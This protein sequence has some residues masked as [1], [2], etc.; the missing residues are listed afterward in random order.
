MRILHTGDWHIGKIINDFS[1]IEDQ[2]YILNKFF[3]IVETQKPDIIIITG[4]IY[5]RSI[6]PKEAVELLDETLTKLIEN[7]KIPT[8]IISGNHDSQERL[9][10][11]SR[12]LEGKKL[13]IEGLLRDKIKKVSFSD[14]YGNVNFYL[15]P[16]GHPSIIKNIFNDESITN[17]NKA[18]EVLINQIKA[19]FNKSERNVLISHNYV[20]SNLEEIL[21]SDSERSLSIGGT[22]YVDVSLVEDFDYVALGHLHKNQKVKKDYIRYSG[23]LLKYSFSETDGDKGVII[24]DLKNKGEYSY[25]FIKLVPCK[26]MRIIKGNLHDLI[27]PTFYNK[28]NRHDYI[29]AK[30]TDE[31]DLYDPISSL[32]AVYPNIMQLQRNNIITNVDSNTRAKGNF[33]NKSKLDLFKEFYYNLACQDLDDSKELV[34]KKIIEEVEKEGI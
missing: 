10:F 18:F 14:K 28:F 25:D 21:K 6:P 7:Y 33:K 12:L 23:S 31:T 22:E 3:E 29:L 1:L 16:Y 26:D 19:E 2:K 32:R 20:I 15:I 8:L 5:D 13:Y 9:S 17:H 4:D 30:L 34:L 24:I 27:Q 11:G